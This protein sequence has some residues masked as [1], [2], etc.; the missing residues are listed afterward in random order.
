MQDAEVE[1]VWDV[2][3]LKVRRSWSVLG[4]AT[5]SYDSQTRRRCTGLEGLESS[6]D[7]TQILCN[8]NR[9]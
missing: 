9:A 3:S 5:D 8:L 1:I 4:I 2:D 7:T 6:K